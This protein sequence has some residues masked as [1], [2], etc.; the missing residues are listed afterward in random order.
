MVE[1]EGSEKLFGM[2]LGMVLILLPLKW[3]YLLGSSMASLA[4]SALLATLAVVF[5]CLQLLCSAPFTRRCYGDTDSSRQ[6][7]PVPHLSALPC[8]HKELFDFVEPLV[9]QGIS[10][11]TAKRPTCYFFFVLLIGLS[12]RDGVLQRQCAFHCTNDCSNPEL[13]C[14]MLFC[15]FYHMKRSTHDDHRRCC[16]KRKLMRCLWGFTTSEELLGCVS[17][18]RHKQDRKMN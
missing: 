11:F 10:K 16:L 14:W 15:M 18:I 3:L 4:T 12:L 6:T 7:C 5:L 13:S 2:V 9:L 1:L 8:K 17:E